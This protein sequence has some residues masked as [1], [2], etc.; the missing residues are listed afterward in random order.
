MIMSKR[1]FC[2]ALSTVVLMS[3]FMQQVAALEDSPASEQQVVSPEETQAE[4]ASET[5]I[6]EEQEVTSEENAE[7]NETDVSSK[8]PTITLDGAVIEN[9]DSFLHQ[10]TTYTSLRGIVQAL[11]PDAVISWEGDHAAVAAEGLSI[12][13]YPNRC[14]FVANG[15]C[16]YLPYG[17]QLQNGTVYLPIR[18]LAKAL[19]AQVS[20]D[21]ATSAIALTSGSGS[22]QSANEYYNADDLYW[23]SRI[24]YAESGNQPLSGK[25]GVGN[26]ILNRVSSFLFPNTIYNVIF[27]RNQFTPASSGSINRTPNEESVLAAKLCLDGAVVLSDALWF[28]RAGLSSWASKHKSYIATIGAHAF[29][30]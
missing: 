1:I 11:R 8:G 5:I 17:V 10:Q 25:I 16:L 26:V 7:T 28:N 3:G 22:I 23:L 9:T 20:W 6:S 27:Q 30:A 13:V 15:R 18:S 29:Y 14:Y 12:T 2:L 21:A 24:I 19:D 4:P